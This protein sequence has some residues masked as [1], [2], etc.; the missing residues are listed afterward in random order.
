MIDKPFAPLYGQTQAAATIAGAVNVNV[1]SGP[2]QLLLTNVGT[3]LAFVRV[4][5]NGVAA[6]ASAT[7]LPLPA[8]AQ[9]IISKEDGG[10]GQAVVVSVFSSGAGSTVY[11]TPG[12]GYGP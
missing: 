5:P 6:D 1:P 10:N 8:G 4:K 3:V 2:K 11:V 7:D 12:E 9:R